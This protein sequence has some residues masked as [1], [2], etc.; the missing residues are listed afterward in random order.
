MPPTFDGEVLS[1]IDLDLDVLVEPD[2]SYRILDNEDF[3]ANA[4][5]YSYPIEVQR[6]V[7][8]ALDELVE[9][10]RNRE[11]PFSD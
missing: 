5:V 7:R 1:Y 4:A 2:L 6:N 8:Q 9:M 3:E 10:I 11:F